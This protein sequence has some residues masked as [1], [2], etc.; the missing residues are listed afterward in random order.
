M[1]VQRVID[2]G[3][4]D[5]APVFGGVRGRTLSS[6][7]LKYAWP[8]IAEAGVKTVIDL[9]N[10]DSSNR[11]V[12]YCEQY[13]MEFFHYPVDM[14]KLNTE[15]MVDRLLRF[16]ELI[17]RGDFYIACAMGLHRTDIAL[18]VYWVFYGADQ[19]LDAPN[20]RGYTEA[21]GHDTNNIMQ[22]LNA[23]YICMTERNGQNPMPEE[24]FKERKNAINEKSRS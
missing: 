7:H 14:K 12:E 17:E 5:V 10:L 8:I 4:P 15:V 21:S 19:G 22:V 11:L 1:D 23:M 18:S 20:L 6:R 3:I 24:V 2:S 16:C 9:R 13:G